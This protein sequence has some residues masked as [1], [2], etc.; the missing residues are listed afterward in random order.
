MHYDFDSE[1]Y[2]D[3]SSEKMSFKPQKEK[4]LM[5]ATEED[6]IKILSQIRAIED[7]EMKNELKKAF[8]DQLK[9]SSSRNSGKKPLFVD[10]SFERNTRSFQ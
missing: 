2:S 3:S 1:S 4:I 6:E 8:M 10:A 5:A 7:G 9:S